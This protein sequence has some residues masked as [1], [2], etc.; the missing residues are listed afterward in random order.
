[1]ST[2][3]YQGYG[4]SNAHSSSSSLHNYQNQPHS[5]HGSNNENGRQQYTNNSS[6]SNSG[7]NLIS[8][9]SSNIISIANSLANSARRAGMNSSIR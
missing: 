6:S 1:Q 4:I 7:G 3:Q 8:S 9:T 2:N 5:Q